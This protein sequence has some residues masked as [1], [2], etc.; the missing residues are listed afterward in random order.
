MFLSLSHTLNIS[1]Y[2]LCLYNPNNQSI[3]MR[4]VVMKIAVSGSKQFPPHTTATAKP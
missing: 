3:E 2:S 4:L 1:L